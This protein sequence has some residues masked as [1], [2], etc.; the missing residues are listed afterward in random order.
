M[1]IL[2]QLSG[3]GFKNAMA[4][5]TSL[6]K[7]HIYVSRRPDILVFTLTLTQSQLYVESRLE[8][9]LLIWTKC[10]LHDKKEQT[11]IHPS[12]LE[13]AMEG[14]VSIESKRLQEPW[15]SPPHDNRKC[16]TADSCRMD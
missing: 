11:G 13:E 5:L 3:E 12:Y 2:S 14:L 15:S 7:E 16:A 6:S 4:R 10:Y 1:V 8:D 9:C